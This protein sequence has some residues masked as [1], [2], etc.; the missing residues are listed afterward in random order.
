MNDGLRIGFV[1]V[2]FVLLF[3]LLYLG[4]QKV[5]FLRTGEKFK[6]LLFHSSLRGDVT[7][8]DVKYSLA[9]LIDSFICL[10]ALIWIGK[11]VF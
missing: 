1:F 3:R 10:V 9:V 2:S 7:W 5:A 8:R 11:R 6:F 4:W